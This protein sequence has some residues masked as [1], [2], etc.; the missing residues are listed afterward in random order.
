MLRV[1]IPLTVSLA[2]LLT[3]AHSNRGEA[4]ESRAA[5]IEA[6][7]AEKAGKQA[8]YVPRGAERLLTKLRA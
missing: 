6:Q 5:L 8:P 4:Q 1:R 2:V 7:Q 3:A